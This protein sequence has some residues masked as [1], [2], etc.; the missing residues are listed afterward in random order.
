M[1]SNEDASIMV[2]IPLKILDK[3][4]EE[5]SKGKFRD[6]EEYILEALKFCIKSENMESDNK[7]RE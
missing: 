2:E 7:Q 3:I 4:D 1:T 6:R 5:V